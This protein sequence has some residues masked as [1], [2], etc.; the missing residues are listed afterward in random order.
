[1]NNKVMGLIGLAQKAGCVSSGEQA[2]EMAVRSG[3]RGVMIL[4]VDASKN[5]EKKFT[6][7]C[8]Y[9]NVP[10]IRLGSKEELGRTIGKQERSV[11]FINEKMSAA[12]IKKAEE[13]SISISNI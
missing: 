2:C 6:D 7:K 9:Y 3:N 5:T 8:A 10:L 4:A 1:M 11:L 13:Q 12:V